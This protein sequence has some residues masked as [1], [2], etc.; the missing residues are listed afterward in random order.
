M[1][2]TT[3]LLFL[4][5]S[6][7]IPVT[8]KA[9]QEPSKF[10]LG[11]SIQAYPAGIIPTIN[12]EHQVKE[13]QSIVY[14]IG[15]NIIDRQDF[16]EEN[17]NETGFGYGGSA[18]YRLHFPTGKN[19]FIAGINLDLWNTRID[20]QD[21]LD[22]AAPT[23]GTTD[24]FVV[25]PWLEGGYFLHLNDTSK[26]GVTAGFGREINVITDGDAV[27]QGF[28]ASLSLQYYIRL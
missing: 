12:L 4:I 28:I 23:S 18:G 25:Q 26:L 19:E 2:Y 3:V 7:G 22:T 9:Q 14:R 21:N 10:L 5:I 8:V 15:V 16:S 20:W 13:N 27:G 17:D 11:A 1:K 6:L 24:T